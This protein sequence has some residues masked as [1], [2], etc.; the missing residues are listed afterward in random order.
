[1]TEQTDTIA[2]LRSELFKTLRGLAD[3]NEP[4]DIDRAKAVSDVAQTLINT[5]KVEIEHMKVSGSSGSDFIAGG[6]GGA[7]SVKLVHQQPGLRVTRNT[8]AG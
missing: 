1:M 6:G 2:Q 5:A 8:L 3:K 4:M 7:G